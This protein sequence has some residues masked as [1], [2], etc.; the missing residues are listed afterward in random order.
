MK[1]FNEKEISNINELRTAYKKLLVKFHP[2]NNLDIDTTKEI[3][4]INAE[5]EIL[6]KK[7]KDFFESSSQYKNATDRE[8]QFYD[9]EKDQSIRD[10]IN[11]LS[12]IPN[13]IIEIIGC[14]VWVSGNTYPYRKELKELGLRFCNKKVAWSIHFD[15]Y[16]KRHR[17]TATMEHIRNKYGSQVV[18]PNKTEQLQEV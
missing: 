6:F 5:Y 4:E 13:I 8:K 17:G 7:L 9:Y 3:Q 12:H 1:W 18:T 14:W 15:D 10:I 16:Y 11:K 2:D